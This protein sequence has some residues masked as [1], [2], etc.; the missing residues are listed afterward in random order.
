MAEV[1]VIIPTYNRADL[2]PR[3]IGSVVNQTFGDFELIVVDDGSTDSTREVVGNFCRADS[4]IR[5]IHQENSGSP[6]APRNVGIQQATGRYIA[7]LDHDD[8]WLPTKIEKQRSLFIN[9]PADVGF[10]GCNI[11][12]VDSVAGE[13]L[14]IHD[15]NDY[16]GEGFVKGVLGYNFVLTAS[17]VIAR[18]EVFRTVGGFD[19]ALKIG[20]DLDMW[21]RIS[22]KFGFD[23][24]RDAL[25]KY[26]VHK[27]NASR[28]Q[29]FAEAT[30]E[31]EKIF[32]KHRSIYERYPDVYRRI[33]RQLGS[34]FCS[35][36]EAKRGRGY[37]TELIRSGGGS[38]ETLLLYLSSFV[39]GKEVYRFVNEHKRKSPDTRVV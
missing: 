37:Y 10:I 35:L 22:D 6:A 3:A 4:R 5:Y 25:V 21:L 7:F 33:L 12:I 16:M 23:F 36:G 39:L 29:D 9:A 38:A 28:S 11:L 26:Y 14:R 15:L 17:A 1:S 18:K 24:V 30:F 13:V 20:D 19:N 32:V 31:L 8:E 2:L 34:K 27:G